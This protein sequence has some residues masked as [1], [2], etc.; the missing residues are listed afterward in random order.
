MT[1]WD[2]SPSWVHWG[3]SGGVHTPRRDPGGLRGL[4]GTKRDIWDFSGL[5]APEP[6]LLTLRVGGDS[7]GG[8]RALGSTDLF[9]G[10]RSL[11]SG[12]L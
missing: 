12:T 3:P 8:L 5:L 11:S 9:K 4:L 2:L 1:S 7:S 10:P 6:D